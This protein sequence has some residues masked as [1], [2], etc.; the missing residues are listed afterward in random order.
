MINHRPIV[1]ALIFSILLPSLVLLGNTSYAQ[2]GKALFQTNCAS[3]H[4]PFKD[5]TGP[6]LK[7]VTSRVTDTKLLHEWIHNNQ[8]VL[9]SG[10]KYFN[11]LFVKFNKTPMNTFPGLSDGE[12][13]AILKYVETATPP[14]GGGQPAVDGKSPE[15]QNQEGD[16]TL[17]YGILSLILAVIMFVLLQVNSSL[18]KLADD[19]EGVPAA[20]PVPFWRN[21]VYIAFAILILILLFRPSGLLGTVAQ[22]KV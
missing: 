15:A 9:A 13:D 2:D 6:A 10:N 17:L 18:K 8:K 12:I 5:I 11:D 3:C 21:K 20:E 16:N 14:G 4:S 7:G 1:R 22:E 19:R